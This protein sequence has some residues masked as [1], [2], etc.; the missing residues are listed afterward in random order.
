MK[1]LK[2]TSA[3]LSAAM[4][5][6]MVSTPVSVYADET[7]APSETQATEK[8]EETEKKAEKLAQK[9]EAAI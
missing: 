4:L 8:V 6:S 9:T 2:V 7:E 5:V 3:L 1:H